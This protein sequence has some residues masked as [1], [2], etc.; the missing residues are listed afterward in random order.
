MDNFYNA[1]ALAWILKSI[2]TDCVGTL[3]INR[4]GVPL[5]VKDK[6]LKKGGLIAQHSGPVSVLKWSNKK[7]VTLISTYHGDDAQKVK[8]GGQEKEKPVSVLDYNQNMIGV[9]LNNQLLHT[10]VLE[11][12]KN[13]QVVHQMVSEVAKCHNSKSYDNLQ[14]KFTGYQN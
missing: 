1:P 3:Q 8:T 7:N 9:D 2:K 4:K 10:H 13:D 11:R 6:K 5:A 12:K 14:G